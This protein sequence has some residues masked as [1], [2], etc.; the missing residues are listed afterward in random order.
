MLHQPSLH[1]PSLSAVASLVAPANR[2]RV[3][4]L[5]APP[6]PILFWQL[7]TLLHQ[8]ILHPILLHHPYRSVVIVLVAPAI[9]APSIPFC[10][11]TSMAASA[12]LHQ[13]I[14]HLIA[15]CR[16]LL[17]QLSI[18]SSHHSVAPPISFCCAGSARLSIILCHS[19]TIHPILSLHQYLPCCTSTTHSC[20]FLA[21]TLLHQSFPRLS[22]SL[23]SVLSCA[24]SILGHC[25]AHSLRSFR[26]D[27]SDSS[28]SLH[29]SY[30][31][32]P[33]PHCTSSRSI[34]PAL[35]FPISSILYPGKILR[36]KFKQ[37]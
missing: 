37:L 6:I 30:Q 8:L 23:F 33:S 22:T 7:S 14:P 34:V 24:L 15:P 5:V 11:C 18:Y 21:P 25:T 29:F 35:K 12:L 4:A 13:L 16:A 28:S 10:H 20:H 27:A 36:I 3:V 32:Y 31:T 26:H 9:I 2:F 19:C 1:H 17:H